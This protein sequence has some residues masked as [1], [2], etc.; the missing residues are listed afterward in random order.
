MFDTAR[1]LEVLGG[2]FVGTGGLV[3]LV[4]WSESSEASR[5]LS[6]TPVTASLLTMAEG[7]LVVLNGIAMAGD[8]E[9]AMPIPGAAL[10]HRMLIEKEFNEWKPRPERDGGGS[11]ETKSE[12]VLDRKLVRGIVITNPV[13][14]TALVSERDLSRAKGAHMIKVSERFDEAE[15]LSLMGGLKT[16]VS[17]RHHTGTRTTEWALPE[18]AR[19]S[20]V[21]KLSFK[22]G[23]QGEV[24]ITAPYGSNLVL[25]LDGI[26]AHIES[27]LE[28]AKSDKVWAIV[29]SAIGLGLLATSFFWV[30]PRRARASGGSG[31]GSSGGGSGG[32]V[33]SGRAPAGPVFDQQAT[34]DSRDLDADCVVCMSNRR[35]IANVPCGHIACC[36]TCAPMTERCPLCR[37]ELTQPG[38][39]L[40]R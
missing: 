5:L 34:A 10:V 9:P 35:C 28:A 15:P 12:A 14:G 24:S 7:T 8:R 38:L 13:A 37:A 19:V 27:L 18:G 23:L 17:G 33:A 26:E 29:L 22:A 21:G 31:S 30:R 6:A 11:W 39:R 1:L 32:G 2:V 20:V 36:E 16:L 25:T 40:F 4:G 3:A